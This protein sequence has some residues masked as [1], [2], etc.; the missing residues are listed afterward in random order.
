[1]V[2][3]DP[4]ALTK[5]LSRV[6]SVAG[7]EMGKHAIESRTGTVIVNEIIGKLGKLIEDDVCLVA[8]QLG[9]FVV[10]FLDIALRAARADDIGRIAHPLRQP[11]KALGAHACGQ[12]RNT[13]TAENARDRH[14]A[15]AIVSSR[16]PDRAVIRRINLTGDQPRHQAGVSGEN[17][18]CADHR[19]AP[20]EQDNDG[21]FYTGEC[22]GQHDMAGHW[23]APSGSR[24]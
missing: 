6:T 24:R 9:A 23:H 20:A 11:F 4:V 13:T 5:A 1:M 14:A 22:L 16:W 10:D 19:E 3:A 7:L 12:N 17:L 15:A 2:P 18:V 21:R 8:R